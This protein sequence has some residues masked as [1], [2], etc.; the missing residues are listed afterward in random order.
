M[1]YRIVWWKDAR[2][3]F[4]ESWDDQEAAIA[5]ARAKFPL[6]TNYYD[7]NAVEI[8]DENNRVVFNLESDP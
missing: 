6:Q 1:S 7:S 2:M 3:I 4:S 5:H 8:T